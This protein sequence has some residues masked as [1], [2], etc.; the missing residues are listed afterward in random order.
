[1]KEL[2]ESIENDDD[3]LVSEILQYEILDVLDKLYKNV[4]RIVS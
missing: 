1:M 4:E 3:N 2:I